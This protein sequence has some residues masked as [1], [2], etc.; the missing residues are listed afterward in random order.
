MAL[1]YEN[2]ITVI[3]NCEYEELSNILR[4]QGFNI[5][6]ELRLVDTYLFDGNQDIYNTPN[7][8]ILR[9]YVLVR[10]PSN[11]TP[12]ITYKYKEINEDGSILKQG[13]ANCD[14]KDE[15]Q[16]INLLE[17]LGYK[18]CFVIDNDIKFYEKDDARLVAAY[19]NDEYL[20]LE[21]SGVGEQTI[22]EVIGDF[23][24]LGV[25]YDENNY[26]VN[27]AMM[28]LDKIK[29]KKKTH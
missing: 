14:V 10:V 26:F 20:C 29:L 11:N 7:A 16:A 1:K 27:K 5:T 12:Q 18:K 17:C 2:E 19:V 23:K 9:N 21:Y 22:E 6:N 15:K 4:A 8:E 3:V 25:P 24:K 13:K 28:E